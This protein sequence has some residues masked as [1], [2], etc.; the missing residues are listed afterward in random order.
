MWGKGEKGLIKIK[1][2]EEGPSK[3]SVYVKMP[4]IAIQFA[5]FRLIRAISSNPCNRVFLKFDLIT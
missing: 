1:S 5:S 2:I 4:R 3:G